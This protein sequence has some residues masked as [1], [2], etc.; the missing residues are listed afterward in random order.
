MTVMDR[1]EDS[2]W[3]YNNNST[4]E[5]EHQNCS[6]SYPSIHKEPSCLRMT[7]V[8][9]YSNSTRTYLYRMLAV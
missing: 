2:D 1:I 9:V 8:L 7:T 3:S 5:Q 6:L 4:D